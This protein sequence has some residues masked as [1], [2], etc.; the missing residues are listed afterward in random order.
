MTNAEL[1]TE[2]PESTAEAIANLLGHDVGFAYACGHIQIH[3]N[4]DLTLS[5]SYAARLAAA[6]SRSL[7]A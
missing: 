6:A 7:P 5:R 4:G 1:T 3:S 2:T